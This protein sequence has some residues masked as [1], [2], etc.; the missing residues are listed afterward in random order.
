MKKAICAVSCLALL[1]CAASAH[2]GDTDENDGHYNRSTGEYHYHHGYNAHQHENGICPYDYDD[3]TGASS[4]SVST[5]IPISDSEAFSY[6][7][8]RGD[9][10]PE[11]E[12]DFESKRDAHISGFESGIEYSFRDDITGSAYND[13]YEDGYRD[14]ESD[15]SIFAWDEGHSKGYDQGYSD[16]KRDAENTTTYDDATASDTKKTIQNSNEDSSEGEFA[17]SIALTLACG[18]G[19]GFWYKR[20]RLEKEA[21]EWQEKSNSWYAAYSRK[22]KELHEQ[23]N[24][25]AAVI[26]ERNAT[27]NKLL[28]QNNS[29]AESKSLS[30][31]GWPPSVHQQQPQYKRY[32]RSKSDDMGIIAQWSDE[33]IIQ[34]TSGVYNTTLHSCTCP[35]FSG[36][37]HGHAPCKHIYFLARHLGFDVDSIFIDFPHDPK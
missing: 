28:A 21:A 19:C 1:V 16:G 22:E 36:N 25:H 35:D 18:F 12:N 3:Q 29:R 14:G 20:K 5:T 15:S 10:G 24:A 27:I 26:A 8:E 30:F 11:A 23:Q 34:G 4:G 2:P 7:D 33:Y 13:G 31:D 6:S 17:A 9:Y 32:Q 37:L